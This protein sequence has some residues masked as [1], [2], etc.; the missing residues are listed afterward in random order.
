MVGEKKRDW[1]ET[2]EMILRT[3]TKFQ[4]KQSFDRKKQVLGHTM[5]DPLREVRRLVVRD[6]ILYY[7]KSQKLPASQSEH[8]NPQIYVSFT[9]FVVGSAPLSLCLCI[10]VVERVALQ[11]KE[12]Q[13]RGRRS[14]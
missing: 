5:L 7:Q 12:P 2:N 10:R 4:K 3:F 1:E 11:F 8:K 9:I 13:P 6:G 14:S